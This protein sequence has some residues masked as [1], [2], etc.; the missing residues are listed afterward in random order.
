MHA[1][2]F[3]SR[4]SLALPCAKGRSGHVGC[5]GRRRQPCG[6]GRG[7]LPGQV[8]EPSAAKK[9][10]ARSRRRGPGVSGARTWENFINRAA[11][12]ERE[13][14]DGAG[15]SSQPSPGRRWNTESEGADAMEDEDTS[16]LPWAGCTELSWVILATRAARGC[17]DAN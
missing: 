14:G 5:Q 1:T 13:V 9:C 12:S 16:G 2:A 15:E 3:A 4:K 17:A 11:L 8:V 6:A 10:A 7:R